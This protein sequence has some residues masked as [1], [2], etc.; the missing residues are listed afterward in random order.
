MSNKQEIKNT[1]E[2]RDILDY[3]EK[4]LSEEDA[5]TLVNWKPEKYEQ[6]KIEHPD[7]NFFIKKRMAVYKDKLLK[8]VNK[9]IESG[10]GK[11][12]QWMLQTKYPDEYNTSKKRKDDDDDSVNPIT[13]IFLAIQNGQIGKRTLPEASAGIH[14]VVDENKVTDNDFKLLQKDAG[15]I[16]IDERR[17]YANQTRR[18]S[19]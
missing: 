12:A 5:H 17:R 8:E 7:F 13:Q 1:Q 4:G 18:N 19:K 15:K 3:I 6:Y 10:D 16:V 14:K 2:A 9:K 11:T